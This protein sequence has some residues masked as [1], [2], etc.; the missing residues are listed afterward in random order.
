[1]ETS[2][3]VAQTGVFAFNPCHISLTDN[4]VACWNKVWV[5]TWA[6]LIVHWLFA[7]QAF[8]VL[9]MYK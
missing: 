2:Q 1:M 4:L 6:K 7:G 5:S 8:K 9:L 3:I